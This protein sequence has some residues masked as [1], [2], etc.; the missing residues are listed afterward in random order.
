VLGVLAFLVW[1][2]TMKQ[3]PFEKNQTTRAAAES[4]VAAP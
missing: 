1:T 3:W 2:A 4:M